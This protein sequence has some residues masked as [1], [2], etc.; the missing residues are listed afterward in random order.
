[1]PGAQAE[2]KVTQYLNEAQAMEQ[3]LI[4]T[5]QAHIAMTPRGSYR[6][7]L[8]GHLEETR[9]HSRLLAERLRELSPDRGLLELGIWVAEFGVGVA[10]S[11]TGR[12]VAAGK[13]PLDMLRGS[14]GEEKLLKNAKD[15][16]ASE[17]LEIAT[18]EALERLAGELGDGKTAQL[19]ERIRRDEERMLARLREEIKGLAAQV[20]QADVEGRPAY[21]LDRTGAADAARATTR[22]A[23]RG[24]RRAARA[25]AGGAEAASG[26][27]A[28]GARAAGRRASGA[29]RRADEAAAAG[30]EQTT[31]ARRARRPRATAQSPR[32]RRR[33][34]EAEGRSADAAPSSA[35]PWPGY[36]GQTV[37]EVREGL[38]ADAGHT[39]AEVLEYERGHKDRASVE[40]AAERELGKTTAE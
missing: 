24:T 37:P 40:R 25:A 35:E 36:D 22:R 10:Q 17:A 2:A 28:R 3:A 11:V 29:A 30:G 39:A 21:R 4:Q 33:G 15:E 31:E 8:E 32:R 20:V 18:Y 12:L 19:A 26:A 14:G 1:M 9:E 6:D 16:C 23:V 5:L 13:A 27:A 34:A 7:A 38:A